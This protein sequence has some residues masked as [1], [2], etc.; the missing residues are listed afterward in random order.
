[1]PLVWIL[2]NKKAI[3]IGLVFLAIAGT[4]T[5]QYVEI[6]TLQ[7][8]KLVL[9]G[10][11][12]NLSKDLNTEMSNNM[13]LKQVNQ[14]QA[15]ELEKYEIDQIQA[16]K[17]FETRQAN[18]EAY[19]KKKLQEALNTNIVLDTKTEYTQLEAKRCYSTM[20]YLV[21]TNNAKIVK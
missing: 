9:E 10:N 21:E 6:Q 11:V 13:T 12:T 2:N 1:M 7:A 8:Q 18:T 4:I 16:K 20:K 3:F 14:E 15:A 19:Y 5:F 17:S